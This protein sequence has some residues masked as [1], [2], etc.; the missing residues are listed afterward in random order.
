MVRRL[1]VLGLIAVAF[2]LLPQA[3]AT[4][5]GLAGIRLDQRAL[6]LIDLPVYGAPDFIGPLGV[7]TTWGIVQPELPLP[8]GGGAAPAGG[9]GA[10]PMAGATGYPARTGLAAAAPRAAYPSA[11]AT[12]VRSTGPRGGGMR[13][14]FGLGRSP[15]RTGAAATTAGT[16]ATTPARPTAFRFGGL[17]G[18]A[19]GTSATAGAQPARPL[20]GAPAAEGGTSY[21]LYNKGSNQVIVGI[22]ASGTVSS[23]T[24]S[25]VSFPAVKTE[26]GVRLGDSYTSVLDKYGFPDTT[27]NV[28]DALVLGYQNAG[29]TLT[30]RNM[31]VQTI[32][33]SKAAPAPVAA[34]AAG[35]RLPGRAPGARTLGPVRS[36]GPGTTSR[37]GTRSTGPP[38]RGGMRLRLNRGAAQ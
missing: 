14:S 25:G 23:V 21:W 36:T 3:Y 26:G 11:A 34:P 8:A 7:V 30:L 5:L 27:Q 31:R 28:G 24:V 15:A 18:G 10:T 2:A 32:A 20:A 29:L 38:R 9:Y 12:G 6:D 1:G 22:G 17:G 13:L 33:L 35:T 4:E 37:T 19:L 16:T